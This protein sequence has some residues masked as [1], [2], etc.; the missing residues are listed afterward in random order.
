[1]RVDPISTAQ[2][3]RPL[4]VATLALFLITVGGGYFLLSAAES[5]ELVDG[6]VRWQ[7]QSPLRA[8]VRLLCMNYAHPTIHQGAIK[9]YLLGIGGAIASIALGIAL[10]A[11]S[12][13]SSSLPADFEANDPDQANEKRHNPRGKAR[14]SP[15]TASQ[16]MLGLLVLWSFASGRWSDAPDLAIGASVLLAIHTLW[17]L[18]LAYCLNHRAARIASGVLL[19]IATMAALVAIWYFHGRNPTI[20]AKFPFGNPTFLAAALIP[21]AILATAMGVDQLRHIW[22]ARSARPVLNAVAAFLALI[23]ITYTFV[24]SGSRGPA[25]GL[26]FGLLAAAFFA[27][28]GWRKLIP[29]GGGV[30]ILVAGAFALPRVATEPSDT[31]RDSSVRF[32]LY[33]AQYALALA[34]EKPLTGNGQAAYVR[35][36]DNLATEDVLADPQPFAARIAHAHNEWLEVLADLGTVGLALV[37]AALGLCLHAG[38]QALKRTESRHRWMLIALLGSLVGLIVEAA[39]GVGLRVSGVGTV[40]YTVVGLL[41]SLCG[42]VGLN[43]RDALSKTGWA[44]HAI[45]ASAMAF[46][47]CGLVLNQ[48]DFDAARAAFDAQR[49]LK[50]GKIQEAIPFAEKGRHRLNPQRALIGEYRVADAHVRAARQLQSQGADRQARAQR[51]LTNGE[52]LMALSMEDF[53]QSYE[54][55][56][57]ASDALA[58][59]LRKSPGFMNQGRLDYFL[60]LTL[61]SLAAGQQQEEQFIRAARG[62]IERELK[63]QPYSDSI[64][65]A[66]AQ[67]STTADDPRQILTTLARPLRY[68]RITATYYELFGALFADQKMPDALKDVLEQIGQAESNDTQPAQDSLEA[69]APELLRIAATV[70]FMRGNYDT[71]V[72]LLTRAASRYE[73]LVHG[74]SMATASCYAELANALFY[75][76]PEAPAP[77]IE[78]AARALAACPDSLPGRTLNLTT[79]HRQVDYLLA[80]GDEDRAVD[81]LRRTAPAEVSRKTI[82]LELAVRYLKLCE[83]VLGRRQAQVLRQA[84]TQMAPRLMQWV[85]RSIALE[86][87]D[88]LA[89][90]MAADLVFHLGDDVSAVAYLREAIRLQMDP[91][92]VL[93]FVELALR[94]KPNSERLATLRKELKQRLEAAPA[95]ASLGARP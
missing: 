28:H 34:A 32:R 10:L 13:E 15:V 58:S 52:Q 12:P 37:L 64:A 53:Q 30:A 70:E 41:W 66:W 19:G 22:H 38:H 43:P 60:N 14:I 73:K 39:T 55:C 86:P 48:S 72:D 7:A 31:G 76:S 47:I 61:A 35:L 87:S 54:H 80:S 27:V 2:K 20:R 68:G 59:L 69:W 17:P 11:R 81:V 4:H 75:R 92:Q 49:L 18:S 56:V 40:F 83:T 62:A 93:Q 94:Q 71:A 67:L 79:R 74:T 50:S 90:F 78:H 45:G 51:G 33:A 57:A 8:V 21:G 26:V 95:D 82:D 6:A 63:R 23:A 29:I 46:G 91:S 84:P 77:A 5:P 25:L 16:A 42:P 44:R 88:P 85:Q 24:L 89:H 65:A 1:M 36:A 9:V 3:L